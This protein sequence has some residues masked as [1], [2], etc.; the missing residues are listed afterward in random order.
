[1]NFCKNLKIELLK[2]RKNFYISLIFILIYTIAIC[3]AIG[4]GEN[5]AIISI[6]STLDGNGGIAGTSSVMYLFIPILTIMIN[7]HILK[8]EK[9]I[10]LI[11][12]KNRKNIFKK[13]ILFV[14][15]ISLILSIIVVIYGYSI[16]YIY[17]GDIHNMWPK[18]NYI[19]KE[20]MYAD[21]DVYKMLNSIPVYMIIL[22]T[23]L[24]K[25]LSFFSICTLIII[26]KSFI[27]NV[28]ILL[29][30]IIS[31]PFIDMNYLNGILFM[32]RQAL[33][34]ESWINPISFSLQVLYLIFQSIV[35]YSIGK[36]IYLDRDFIKE[37]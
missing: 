21:I 1:M 19:Y 20:P 37:E 35:L 24:I 17:A 4:F 29:L 12:F 9:D 36:S 11:K 26:M 25:F 6:I 23:I 15:A 13:Y 16:G 30:T 27:N 14:V 18:N 22:K 8:S 32:S 2:E 7:S 28:G 10:Y 3:Y 31:I 34:V 5:K 33:T